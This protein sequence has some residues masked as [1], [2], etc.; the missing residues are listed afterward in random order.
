MT[1]RYQLSIHAEKLPRSFWGTA[2]SPYAKVKISGGPLNGKEI[3]RTATLPTTVDADWT[4]SLYLETA[5]SIFMPL[6]IQIYDDQGV[7]RDDV[8][9]G[10]ANCEAT[11]VFSSP[12]HVQVRSLSTGRGTVTISL[13]PSQ[14]GSGEKLQLQLRGLDIRNVEPGLLGLGRS[15]PFFEIAKKNADHA[16]GIVGWNVV[17]RSKHIPNHLNPYWD[18]FTMS[19]E[20]LCTGD[21]DLPL[22]VMVKDHQQ[23]RGRH[24]LIG[25]FE[26]T[27]RS[28]MDRIAVKGNADR[29][30]AFDL[31][32]VDN[33]K[34]QSVGLVVVL[35]ARILE[36]QQ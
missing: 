14:A 6:L 35:T 21:L 30:K 34:N 10:Q 32:S 28:L 27:V 4:D 26:T 8:L 15:D 29:E 31:Q 13:Q 25:Q 20:D 17:Y 33:D 24:R 12:G 16:A 2:P 1:T 5:S 9:L 23:Y 3:G 19:L 22:L 18:S 11:E 7:G 36:Q